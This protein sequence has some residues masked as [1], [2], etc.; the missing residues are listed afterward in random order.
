MPSCPYPP[1]LR[2]SAPLPSQVQV[3]GSGYGPV[4]LCDPGSPSKDC[5]SHVPIL[6]FTLEVPNTSP[7][8]TGPLKTLKGH[9][10]HEQVTID[11]GGL[12]ASRPSPS[13]PRGPPGKTPVPV[14]EDCLRQEPVMENAWGSLSARL[15]IIHL[16]K[17]WSMGCHCLCM[18][19]EN[20]HFVRQVVTSFKNKKT[21]A[22]CL[23]TN[24]L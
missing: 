4:T 11:T 5:S 17:L 1:A 3:A 9:H 6:V 2:S 23:P 20:L 12:G 19:T 21:A 10:S 15:L 24:N 13:L 7:H 16:H 14:T 8:Q 22:G 18:I